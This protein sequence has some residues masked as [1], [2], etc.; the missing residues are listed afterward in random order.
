MVSVVSKTRTSPAL[1]L[2]VASVALA[3]AAGLAVTAWFFGLPSKPGDMFLLLTLMIIA[4]MLEWSPVL[5]GSRA[6]VALAYPITIAS[7]ILCGPTAGVFVGVVSILVAQFNQ[8]PA[9]IKAVFNISE[10]SVTR[11][12]SG[13]AYAITLWV[14]LALSGAAHGPLRELPDQSRTLLTSSLGLVVVAVLFMILVASIT[15]GVLIA[16]VLRLAVGASLRESMGS[17]WFPVVFAM[18]LVLALLGVAIAVAGQV[19]QYGLWVVVFAAPLFAARATVQHYAALLDGYPRALRALTRAIEAK[20]EYTKGHSERVATLATA[21]A[22]YIGLGPNQV[23][24]VTY[25]ALLHDLGKLATPAAV[26]GKPAKLTDSEYDEMKLH[27]ERAV[28]I[29]ERIPGTERYL[30]VIRHHHER[31]DGRGYPDGLEGDEIPFESKLLAVCDSYDAM[32]SSRPYRAGMSKEAALAEIERV[33][34][35]QL[36]SDLAVKFVAMLVERSEDDG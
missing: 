21:F 6:S 7:V 32:T 23:E 3:G 9:P 1:S 18:D 5:I 20:D 34:G 16:I 35:T 27:P 19:G 17:W 29:V 31:I 10:A 14:S 33:A 24:D 28:P 11:V 4:S 2:Y 8:R 30:G 12:L 13:W 26:L 25:A 22:E 15:N 36:D